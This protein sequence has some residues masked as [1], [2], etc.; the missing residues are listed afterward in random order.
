MKFSRKTDYGIILMEALRPSFASGKF[1]AL[2]EV[3]RQE[4]LPVLFVA[5][6]AEALCKKGYL[7]AKRGLGGG[8][9]MVRDPKIITLKEL[10]D[11]FEEPPMLRCMKSSDPKKHCSLAATCP[12]R[13]TWNGIDEKVDALFQNVTLASL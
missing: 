7:E 8:Y 1:I 9:R 3:A 13:K 4:G 11:A 10:I 5:K 12:T 2:A 6:L